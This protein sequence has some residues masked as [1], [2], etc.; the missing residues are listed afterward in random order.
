MRGRSRSLVGVILASGLGWGATGCHGALPGDSPPAPFKSGVLLEAPVDA[1]AL[2]ADDSGIYWTSA[3]NELWVLRTGASAP[4]RLAIGAPPP[5]TCNQAT[6]PVLTAIYAFWAPT[7]RASIHRTRKDGTGDEIIAPATR[8]E[9]AVDADNVYWTEILPGPADLGQGGGVVLSLPHGAA[10]GSAPAKRV[11]VSSYD[12]V[13]ALAVFDG[14]LFWSDTEVVG[15]TVSYANLAWGPLSGLDGTW[16]GWA[17]NLYGNSR[18]LS[19][20]GGHVYVASEDPMYVT[21]LARLSSKGEA[22]TIGT[23]PGHG[24]TRGVA[25]VDDWVLVSVASGTC[26]QPASVD[27]AAIPVG[28]GEPRPVATGL[29]TAAVALG[30]GIVFVD[31]SNRLVAMSARDV[32]AILT[33]SPAP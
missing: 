14:S 23:L 2:G 1:V 26:S 17:V 19:V 24:G 20:A 15:T 16:R 21:S 33:P 12:E 13:W 11:Q 9:I 8:A 25:V 7:D 27:L 6:A 31:G 18:G 10:P 30:P 32:E 29:H 22:Q 3:A 4:E 28:G 5:A